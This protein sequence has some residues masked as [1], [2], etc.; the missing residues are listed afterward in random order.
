M[1]HNVPMLNSENV[2]LLFGWVFIRNARDSA[3][4]LDFRWNIGR[5]VGVKNVMKP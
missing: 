2:R 1:F 3:D 5:S 4:V